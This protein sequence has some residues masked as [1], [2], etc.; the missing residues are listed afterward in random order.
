MSS[1]KDVAREAGVSTAT[2]SHVVNNTRYVS[3]EVRAR[4]LGAV[5]R[6]GYYPNA[7]A[8]SLASGRSQTL[9]LV[10]SDISNPFFPEL[11]KSI[12]AAAFE[13]GYDLVLSNTNYDPGRTS[14][15]VRR[16]IER[17]V[18]GVVVMT[19]E[20]DKTLLGELA[21]R[22]VSVVFLDLGKPGVHMSNLSVNYEA[23]IEEAISHLVALGHEEIA[24]VSGPERLRSAARRLE[25]F[26]NSMRRHL[27]RARS[28]LYRGDF[29]LDGGRR[30][31]TE[32][33]AADTRPTAVVA[34][35]DL[36][37]LGVM[38]GLRAA[39]LQIPRDVSVIGFDDIAFAASAEPPLTTVCL[40]RV[41]L[42]RRAVEAL[43]AN[44]EHPERSGVQVNIQTYLI[45]RASTAPAAG[46]AK[47]ARTAAKA[48]KRVKERAR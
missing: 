38:A 44:I 12:E 11:I 26:R 40:P 9:G 34:A 5:E 15:Y 16:F 24:F 33:L 6:C 28:L 46:A 17:K 19:S 37:A 1:I 32:M 29:K 45:T 41:E 47:P 35:N 14:H 43:M 10:V 39:G 30:A 2:V 13:R 18:A 20:L 23:G 25:A 8:R 27:P 31:A 21:R 48:D 42:G 22:D 36:M 3:D 4:V 7:H